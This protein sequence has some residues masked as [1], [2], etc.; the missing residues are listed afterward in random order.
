[1]Y[2]Y[3]LLTIKMMKRVILLLSALLLLTNLRAQEFT[4]PTTTWPYL[5]PMFRPGTLLLEEGKT[6]AY[7]FNIHIRHDKLHFLDKEGRVQEAIL[8]NVLGVEID[9]DRYINMGGSMLKVLAQNEKGCV[10]AEILGDFAALQ[11][12]GGAYGT[13]S[14]TSATRKLTSLETDAQIN[15]NHMILFQSKMD[16]QS[17]GLVTHYYLVY[18]GRQVPAGKS[19]F[20]KSLTEEQKAEWKNWKKNHKTKWDNPESLLELLDFLNP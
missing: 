10:A 11:E 2:I 5:Y 13:S 8:T 9:G 19:A 1:M 14:T 6:K 18:N 16:G 20:Q 4:G 7:D 3:A 12:T 17:V 15:Q